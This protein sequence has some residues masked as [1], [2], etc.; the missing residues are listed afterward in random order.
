MAQAYTDLRA[1]MGAYNE[2]MAANAAHVDT[3]SEELKNLP[4]WDANIR[5]PPMF[6]PY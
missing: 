3:V 4:C 1:V 2:V 5:A 6:S